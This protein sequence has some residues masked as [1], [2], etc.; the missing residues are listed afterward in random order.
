M[1]VA[2]R[3]KTRAALLCSVVTTWRRR[4]QDPKKSNKAKTTMSGGSATCRHRG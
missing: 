1:R 4:C 2:T 3:H